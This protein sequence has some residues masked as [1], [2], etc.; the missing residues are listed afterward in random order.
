MQT[1]IPLTCAFVALS[2]LIA[3]CPSTND[4]PDAAKPSEQNSAATQSDDVTEAIK[5]FGEVPYYV[6]DLGSHNSHPGG[7]GNHLAIG[8]EV[9]LQRSGPGLE[10]KLGNKQVPVSPSPG[11]KE[12]RGDSDFEHAPVAPGPPEQLKHQVVVLRSTGYDEPQPPAPRCVPK[13]P[14]RPIIDIEFCPEKTGGGW[15]CKPPRQ[16]QGDVHAQPSG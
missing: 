5:E 16:H 1:R 10:L 11:G 13:D 4:T 9:Q 15:E 3:G 8:D 2:T 7:K 12:L 6:C 14:K